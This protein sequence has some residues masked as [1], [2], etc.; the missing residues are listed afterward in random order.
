MNSNHIAIGIG[1][2]AAFFVLI[3]GPISGP[4]VDSAYFAG[5]A[6]SLAK[7]GSYSFNGQP[8]NYQPVFPFILAGFIAF[9][10]S[11]GFLMFLVVNALALLFGVYVFARNAWNQNVALVAMAAFA[12]T[13]LVIYSSLEL[14]TDALFL[15]FSIWSAVAYLHLQKKINTQSIAIFFSILALAV[16]TR[17]VGLVLIGAYVAHGLWLHW[18]GK[19]K[20]KVIHLLAPLAAVFLLGILWIAASM[21]ISFTGGPGYLGLLSHPPA[22]NIDVQSMN[23]KTIVV[24]TEETLTADKTTFINGPL[25]LPIPVDFNIHAHVIWPVQLNNA[26]R[27]M[28]YFLLL[29]GVFLVLGLKLFWLNRFWRKKGSWLQRFKNFSSEN[30]FLFFWFLFIGL[31]HI[32]FPFPLPSRY[33]L[34]M[35]FPAAIWFGQFCAIDFSKHKKTVVAIMVMHLLFSAAVVSWDSQTRWQS[36][37]DAAALFQETGKWI[38]VHAPIDSVIGSMGAPA[39]TLYFYSHRFSVPNKGDFLVVS[40]F[41]GEPIAPPLHLNSCVRFE[42]PPVWTEVYAQSCP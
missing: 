10:G 39:G 19:N 13:P 33:V 5:T 15:T 21:T 11:A 20:C 18:A 8:V 3:H 27:L 22:G 42:K 7:S 29:S 30:A 35:M 6:Q 32:L 40:N 25:V 34:P 2:L 17:P 12:I 31:F 16:L 36:N 26:V 37:A 4:L 1:I 41:M 38:D 28:V 23:G 14:L 9:F 24:F